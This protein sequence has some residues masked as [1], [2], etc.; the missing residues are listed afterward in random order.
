MLLKV[1]EI[2]YPLSK[3][4][5]IYKSLRFEMPKLFDKFWKGYNINKSNLEYDINNLQ[6]ILVYIVVRMTNFPLMLAHLNLI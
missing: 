6:N 4:E 3:L 5:H 1:N 2:E